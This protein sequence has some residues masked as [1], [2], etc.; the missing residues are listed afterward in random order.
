MKLRG[1]EIKF[2]RT[3]NVNCEIAAL[4]PDND[5]EKFDILLTENVITSI[6]TQATII[7]LLNE[8][9]E[10][11]KH[12]EDPSYQPNVLSVDEIMQLPQDKFF[13]LRNEAWANLNTGA[14]TSIEL[15]ESKKKE[16]ET[17]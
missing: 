2:L 11:N 4:C 13:E 5:V 1:R 14:E 7:H 9:Y 16:K 10:M 15:E 6:K 17:E 3:V 8:G 12:Y